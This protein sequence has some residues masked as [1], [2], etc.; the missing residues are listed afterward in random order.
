MKYN[1]GE[2]IKYSLDLYYHQQTMLTEFVLVSLSYTPGKIH[3]FC[4][5]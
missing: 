2:E 5:K 4:V 3:T 1:E